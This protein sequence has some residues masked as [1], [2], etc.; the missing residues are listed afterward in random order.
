MNVKNFIIVTLFF[1]IAFSACNNDDDNGVL[2]EIVLP[3]D[4]G[5]QQVTDDAQLVDYLKTHFYTPVDVDL[6]GDNVVDYQTAQLD[7]IA[8]TNSDKV[9]IMDSGKLI[10]KEVT[11]FD[12]KYKLY[13]LNIN[14]GMVAEQQPKF[15]DSTY[16][17]YSGDLLYSSGNT[18]FD[19]AVTPVWFDLV[20]VV[21]G[22][23]ESLLDFGVASSFTENSDGT[24]T[25]ADFGHL[26]VF[27]PSGLGYFANPPTGSSIPV[28][29]PLIFNI[30]LYQVNEADHDRDGI[31]SYLEDIN[32][33]RI[34]QDD[35][36]DADTVANFL[37]AD[38]DNDGTLTRDEITVNDANGDGIISLD[39]ITF[40]DDDNDGTF[41]HFDSD[42]RDLKNE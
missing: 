28:Y 39:E 8:G 6:N 20:N 13:I 35:D 40:Y 14:S 42:D 36:N 7:T 11:R 38:D 24:F 22:F 12:V 29:A 37:D 19:S 16:V 15:A 4:R 17:T 3:R 34:I 25:A 9:S 21:D 31:P 18:R 27:M 10:T 1:V 41:N 23:R 26:I 30:Q 2:G 5:E 32:G 33:N